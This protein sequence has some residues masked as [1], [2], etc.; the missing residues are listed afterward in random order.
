MLA[1]IMSL[2]TPLAHVMGLKIRTFFLLKVVMLHIELKGMQNIL[3]YNTLDLWGGVKRPKHFLLKVV[4][5]YIKQKGNKFKTTCKQN[6]WPYFPAPWASGVEFKGQI[7][8]L[9]S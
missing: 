9:C 7:L 2:H 6:V 8:K 1:S 5:L 3:H 4:M